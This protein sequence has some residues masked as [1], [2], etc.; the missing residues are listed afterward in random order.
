MKIFIDTNVLVAAFITH[1]SCN[2]LFVHCMT[3]HH[4]FTSEFSLKELSRTLAKKFKYPVDEIEQTKRIILS[5]A[6]ITTEALLSQP[7]SRDKDD[8]HIIAAAIKVDVDCIL[9]GDNDLL[10]LKKVHGIPIV[11]PRDFWKFEEAFGS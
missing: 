11:S 9:S 1:G 6:T 3:K 10:T 4:V 2:E 7:F 5:G 8:D